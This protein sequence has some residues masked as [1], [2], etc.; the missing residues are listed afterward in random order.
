MSR[1]WPTASAR[2][3][4]DTGFTLL[5]L[6]IGLTLLALMMV[7]MYSAL[8]LGIRAWDTGDARAG[9][10]ADQRIVQSFL[11]REF[12]QTFAI[13]WR[14]VAE[15][16]I[17][18]EGSREKVRFVSAL[19]LEAGLRDVGLQWAHLQLRDDRNADAGLAQPETTAG[20]HSLL[21]KVF[22]TAPF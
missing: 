8:N 11:R 2:R 16:R 9:E 17:V 20:A 14:G 5:E 19:S 13:R 1:H 7:M 22:A 10:A 18:F 4:H 21:K 12:S 15:S 3:H 6:L